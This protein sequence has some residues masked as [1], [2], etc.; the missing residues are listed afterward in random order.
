MKKSGSKS[1]R[2]MK[3]PGTAPGTLIYTGKPKEEKTAFSFCTYSEETLDMSHGDTFNYEK[4]T[5]GE[6]QWID[7]RGVH[8]VEVID[9]IGKSLELHA[10]VLEDIIN[11]HQRAKLEEFPN[12][13]FI[14]LQALSL[15]KNGDVKTQQVSMFYN[16]HLLLSFQEDPDDL[17]L[18]IRNR[19][20]VAGSRMRK[21]NIEY[22]VYAILD[23]LCD[24]YL[25]FL[26]ELEEKIDDLEIAIIN[27]TDKQVKLD[28]H[29]L[30][31][32]MMFFRKQILPLR[33]LVNR[34]SKLNDSPDLNNNYIFYRDLY[35]HII[36]L[37]ES[38]ELAK[39]NLNGLSDLY[40]SQLSLKN[41]ATIQILTIISTIFI[42]ITFVA[43]VYGMN[44]TNMPELEWEYGYAASLLL[45]F[46][47]VC[48]MLFFFYRKRWL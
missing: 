16:E 7:I 14:V 34:L 31:S 43:G 26:N 1:R 33:E 6:K 4:S 20:S 42:P 18:P 11:V 41:N 25:I 15:E 32:K 12:G 13:T 37:T 19:L 39:D 30:R 27:E 48:A 36:N 38:V 22:L 24:Q 21:R 9:A 40:N 23:L 29:E 17:F 35:D 8:N 45:M 44:F 2:K 10:L 28:L 46:G 47:V 5:T 3:P